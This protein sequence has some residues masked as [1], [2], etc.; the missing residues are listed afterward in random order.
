MSAKIRNMQARKADAIKAAR[1]LTDKVAAEDRDLT[2]DEQAEFDGYSAQIASLNASIEREQM[3]ATEEAGMNA[4]GGIEITANSVVSVT[5]NVAADPKRGFRSFG[6]F[7]QAVKTSSIPGIRPDQRLASAPTTYGNESNG[8]DGGYA[9][10]PQFATEIFRL[11]LGE[12]SLIPMTDNT[13]VSGNSMVFPKDETTPWGTDGIRAYWQAEAS[14]A[15]ATKPKLGTTV[16]R[17]HKLMGLVPLTD[18]LIADTN[19]LD[20]YLP[21][22]VG[23][24]IR[25]KANESI[26][27]GTGAG[28]PQGLLNSGAAVAVAKE[29]GQTAATVNIANLSKMLSRLMPGSLNNA[30]WLIHPSVIPQLFQLTIGNYPIFIP[31]GGVQG[32]NGGQFT[33]MGRPVIIS[34]HASVLGTVGDISLLDLTYYRTITKAAGVETATSMHLYFDADATAFRAIFRLDGQSKI[35][36]AVSPAKGSDTLSPF[37]QLATRA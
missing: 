18:E 4:A 31:I 32:V 23:D 27:F 3:L 29:S 16:L 13:N 30:V 26:L 6:E 1:A 33:L 12:D 35:A 2:A 5:D 21:S 20:S 8:A 10:P 24:S 22:K 36:A 19:A 28:Q 37:I 15:T 34:Q 14:A 11:S 9:V 17:L 25:W 7:A